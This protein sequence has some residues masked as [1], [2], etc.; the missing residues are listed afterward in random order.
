[1]TNP[2][3]EFIRDRFVTGIHNDKLRAELLRHKKDD[4]TVV[5]LAEVI[6]KAKAWEASN[7]I[8]TKVME[9]QHT[10]EQVNYTSRYQQPKRWNDQQR[11]KKVDM[12]GYCGGKEAHNRRTC[13]AGKPG[14]Y[15]RN[16]Y[17]AN[18]FAIVCRSPKDHFKRQWLG[19]TRNEKQVKGQ[20]NALDNSSDTDEGEQLN[21]FALSLD[22]QCESIYD[23]SGKSPKKLFTSLS[24]SNKSNKSN[25]RVPFQVDT[26]ATC[27]TMPLDMYLKFGS[28]NAL[29]PTRSTLFSYCGNPIK[30]LGTITL[31]CEAPKKFEFVT[32]QVV[33]NKD[34][35]TKPALLGAADS[36]KL[37]LIKYDKSR[38][39]MSSQN[40][41]AVAT[42]IGCS[43]NNDDNCFM[44]SDSKGNLAKDEFV[45][46]HSESFS[47]LGNLGK[48]V[49]FVIDPKVHPVHAPIHRIPV[50]KRDH[51]QPKTACR[52]HQMSICIKFAPFLCHLSRAASTRLKSRV[53]IYRLYLRLATISQLTNIRLRQDAKYFAHVKKKHDKKLYHIEL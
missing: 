11:L 50:A 4:G 10:D 15:C 16:C 22:T 1:M 17:G 46:N 40:K 6:N 25:K 36:I 45:V 27:N 41:T 33:D 19:K 35:K 32:F 51:R 13:P 26:A 14:V 3:Q 2:E 9:L 20:V 42:D 28:V 23:V 39:H 21:Y 24:L 18:H 53:Y 48:P 12:C 29:K 7:N 43:V 5:T 37:E 30:P 38:V 47:G 49:S 8:N 31:L 44:S 52:M 34:I